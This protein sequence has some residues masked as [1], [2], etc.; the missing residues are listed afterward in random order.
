MANEAIITASGLVAGPFETGA[1][2]EPGRARRRRR[3]RAKPRLRG[4]SHQWA[5]FASLV[6]GAT[7]VS[8]AGTATAAAAAGV[9]ALSMSAPLGVSALYHRVWACYTLYV[10][11]SA[12]C[13]ALATRTL[14]TTGLVEVVGAAGSLLLVMAGLLHLVGG[15][16]YALQRPDPLPAVFGYH[17]IFHAMVVLGATLQ[18]AA[19]AMYVVPAL[20]VAWTAAG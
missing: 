9:F 18:F 2:D 15:A 13:L 3:R 8:L 7:L 12:V 20:D 14:G 4:V 19:M 10:L 6:P 17:E 11:Y 1:T 5:F 16:V